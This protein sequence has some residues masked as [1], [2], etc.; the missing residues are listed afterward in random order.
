MSSSS[1][2]PGDFLKRAVGKE[3]RVR[4]NNGTDY[5]GN[6]SCLDG[7]MNIALDNTREYVSGQFQKSYGD[8]FLRG[9]NVSYITVTGDQAKNE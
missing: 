2:T 9:N 1:I 7:F 6:L 4:L 8:S 3:V 5:S